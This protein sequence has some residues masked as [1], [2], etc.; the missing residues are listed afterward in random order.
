MAITVE[1]GMTSKIVIHLESKM[2]FN[3]NDIRIHRNITI[4]IKDVAVQAGHSCRGECQAK[5][6]VSLWI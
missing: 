5:C 2:S 3:G 4:E 6:K 1:D